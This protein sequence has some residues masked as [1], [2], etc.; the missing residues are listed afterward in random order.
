VVE[1]GEGPRAGSR[2]NGLRAARYVAVGDLDPR[3]ADALLGSLRDEGIAAYVAPTPGVRGGY[4]ELRL[5]SHPSD[6]LYVDEA[7]AAR[8][9]EVMSA[10][11]AGSLSPG[12]DH[13]ASRPPAASDAADVPAD[14]DLEAAWQQVLES[15]QSPT[16]SA[17]PPWPVAEDV[18]EPATAPDAQPADS[19]AGPAEEDEEHYLPPQPPPLPRLRPAT[20]LSLLGIVGG[21]VVLGSD[22]EGGE[23]AWLA[24]IAIIGGAVALIWGVKQGPPPDSGWD[25]GAVV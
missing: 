25:D 10:E 17:V 24:V 11:T 3:V 9:N 14:P 16:T 7:R 23:F 20:V 5:P 2:D 12:R 21:I 6:R 19:A 4:L 8:A 22:V 15:L 1:H 18:T 13:P